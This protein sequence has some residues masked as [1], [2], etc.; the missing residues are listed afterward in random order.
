MLMVRLRSWLRVE[1]CSC[2]IR[3]V[4]SWFRVRWL[5]KVLKARVSSWLR[6]KGCSSKIRMVSS[7]LRVRWPVKIL[8]VINAADAS[9]SVRVPEEAIPNTPPTND[10]SWVEPGVEVS[11]LQLELFAWGWKGWKGINITESVARSK[12]IALCILISYQGTRVYSPNARRY[13]STAATSVLAA[14]PISQVGDRMA[15]KRNRDLE[16]SSSAC[17]FAKRCLGK[18]AESSGNVEGDT[19]EIGRSVEVPVPD[20]I[21]IMNDS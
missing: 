10:P 5:V 6:V 2:K 17:L 21:P 11:S 15:K 1:G 8:I 19:G 20:E 16:T 13:P 14:H 4:S 12:E 9:T 7:W 18:F 3:M